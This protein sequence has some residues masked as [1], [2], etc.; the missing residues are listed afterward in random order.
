MSAFITALLLAL[1]AGT[2]IY[3]KLQQRTGYGNSKSALQG[4]AVSGVLIFIV[5]FVTAMF[6]GIG[7]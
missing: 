5:T 1:G 3:T 2:W 4:A 6:L 7:R